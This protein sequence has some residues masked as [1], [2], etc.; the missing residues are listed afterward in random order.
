MV[1]LFSM[2]FTPVH[3]FAEDG[4]AI[5]GFGYNLDESLLNPAEPNVTPERLRLQIARLAYDARMTGARTLRWTPTDIWPQWRCTN[6]PENAD[7]SLDPNWRTMAGALLEGAQN[8]GLRVV[9][10][11]A[12]ATNDGFGGIRTGSEPEKLKAWAAHRAGLR[13]ADKYPDA[14]HDCAELPPYYA[15]PEAEWF[16]DPQLSARLTQRFVAQARFLAGFPALGGVE[17]F[18]EPDFALTQTADFWPAVA[19]MLRA[20]KSADPALARIPVY[21]GA[22]SWNGEVVAQAKA[23]GAFDLEPFITVHFYDDYTRP[24]AQVAAQVGQAVD[25]LQRIAPGKPVIV[26]EAGSSQPLRQI[27]DNAKMIRVLLNLYAARHVGL[28][29]WG[30]WFSQPGDADFRWDF[31]HRSA[32]GPSLAPYFFDAA[33]AAKYA[34]GTRIQAVRTSGGS[35]TLAF[36]VETIGDGDPRQIGVWGIDL[37]GRRFPGF[38]RAGAFA[39]QARGPGVFAAP[40]PAYFVAEGAGPMQWAQIEQLGEG[41]RLRVFQCGASGEATPDALLGL[42]VDARRADPVQCAA[43]VELYRAAL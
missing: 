7:G 26:A 38:S 43:S 13:G 33:G 15:H 35:E 18:N 12:D 5:G 22:A 25:Y 36:K 42:M 28:W 40:P 39:R 8:Q 20:V 24:E 6:D 27:A 31:N 32:A 34:V 2:F 30:D 10:I 16:T 4:A 3:G 41:W 37:G 29:V 17:L 11:L 23:A 1:A 19:K 14:A 21:S 9:V